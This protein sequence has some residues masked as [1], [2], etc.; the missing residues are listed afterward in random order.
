M[1]YDRDERTMDIQYCEQY[2]TNLFAIRYYPISAREFAAESDS[3]WILQE[4]KSQIWLAAQK[5]LKNWK[6]W[7]DLLTVWEAVDKDAWG[8]IHFLRQGGENFTFN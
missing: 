5:S 8:G 1:M 6:C 3:C 2:H 4:V 7:R